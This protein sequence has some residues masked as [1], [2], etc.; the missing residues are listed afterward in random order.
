MHVTGMGWSGPQTPVPTV[1]AHSSGSSGQ[2]LPP[3]SGCR[4]VEDKT[5]GQ[6]GALTV[7][8]SVLQWLCCPGFTSFGPRPLLASCFRAAGLA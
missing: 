1:W 3:V 7:F 6:S 5:P 8:H 2:M 4:R